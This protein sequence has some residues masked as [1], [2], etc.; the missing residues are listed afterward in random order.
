[1]QIINGNLTQADGKAI[2]E[3]H[4]QFFIKPTNKSGAFIE[5][6]VLPI[7]NADTDKTGFFHFNLTMKK[8]DTILQAKYSGDENHWAAYKEIQIH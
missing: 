7:G 5:S 4:I 1:M 3:A 8:S 6:N 2:S